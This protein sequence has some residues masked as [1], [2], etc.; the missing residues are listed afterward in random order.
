LGHMW[1]HHSVFVRVLLGS[2][3]VV[4]AAGSP[5]F[6]TRAAS[7][8][9]QQ[10]AL[11]AG[12]AEEAL[13]SISCPSVRVCYVVGNQGSINSTHDAGATWRAQPSW[14]PS[15][16]ATITCPAINVC[17]ALTE[18]CLNG[19]SPL[20]VLNTTDGGRTW[21]ERSHPPGCVLPGLACLNVSTCSVQLL[22]S[23]SG[24]EVIHTTDGGR[25]WRSEGVLTRDFGGGVS[26]ALSCPS[27][28]LCYAGGDN[29]IG[30]TAA[31]GK[32]WLISRIG[33]AACSAAACHE[34][35]AIA[36]PTHAICYA[37]G[38]YYR[39]GAYHAVTITTQ[40]GFR[41]WK[42]YLIP[43][44]GAVAGGPGPGANHVLTP[45]I[46]ALSCPTPTTCIALGRAGTIA[47]TT[48]G[49]KSWGVARI[50]GATPLVGVACPS[51][52]VCYAAGRLRR[53]VR[54]DDGGK[55]WR[56]LVP[57]LFFSGT[58]STRPHLHTYSPW[59]TALGPW[60]VTAGV[61]PDRPPCPGVTGVGIVVQNAAGNRVAVPVRGLMP[62]TGEFYTTVRITGRLRVDIVSAHCTDFSVRIDG[63]R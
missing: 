6:T 2:L 32:R 13:R 63:V 50:P 43:A 35:N 9:T 27:A 25:S 16:L 47:R 33:G 26:V 36:C 41:T 19:S 45:G 59:F 31:D 3:L 34:F 10:S 30:R 28:T 18:G 44:L 42:R 39:G 14:W 11:P 8:R 29:A 40:D 60:Q 12:T 46:G 61:Y 57:A 48:D 53:L 17:F 62:G 15:S 56:N 5:G 51:A 49:G 22:R 54:S 24:D 20:P 7:P 23:P 58:Y 4:A 52:S 21:T 1:Q 55:T 37:A 38:S